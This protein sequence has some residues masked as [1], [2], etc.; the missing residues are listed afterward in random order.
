M[1]KVLIVCVSY[2][3]YDVLYDYIKSIDIA[4]KEALDLVQVVVAIVDNTPDKFELITP[5]V[6]YID[7]EVFP[8]HK[9]LGY[10]GGAVSALKDLTK[11]YVSQFEFVIVSNVDITLS[12]D[13]FYN[14]CN[15]EFADDVAWIAPSI[16]R[17]DKSNENPFQQYRISKFKLNLLISMYSCS[18]LYSIYQRYRISKHEEVV[19]QEE[20]EIFAGRGSIFIFTKNFMKKEYPL[21][22]P[23]FMYGEEVYYGELVCRNSMKTLFVPSIEVYNIGSVSTG[24]LSIK[25]KCDM[26]KD[27]LKRIKKVIYG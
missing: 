6:Q 11:E 5:K 15:R 22:F 17:Q 3:S 24:K 23:S 18:T 19:K 13:F 9:N 25:R 20:K 14:L 8:Y 4:A 10:M 16:Y 2:N 12:K 27:S 26:N 1:K 7:V 21:T